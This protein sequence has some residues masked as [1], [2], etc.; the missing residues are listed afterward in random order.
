MS[1]GLWLLYIMP[2]KCNDKN[3]FRYLLLQF[4]QHAGMLQPIVF[5]FEFV[6]QSFCSAGTLVEIPPLVIPYIWY[7][8]IQALPAVI[9]YINVR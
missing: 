9:K 2:K 7:K 5:V 4:P 6:W 3:I 8:L 1:T